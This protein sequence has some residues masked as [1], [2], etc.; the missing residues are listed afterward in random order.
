MKSVGASSPTEDDGVRRR[1]I[2]ITLIAVGLAGLIGTWGPF[3]GARGDLTCTAPAL[4]GETVDVSVSDTGAMMGSGHMLS[5][6][7]SP[8][9]VAPGEVSFIV[10][11]TG[12]MVHEFLVLPLPPGGAGSRPVGPDGRVSEAGSLGEASASCAEGTGAG[13]TPG[14]VSWITLRMASG[15][16]E[17]ICNEPGHYTSGM[18]TELDVR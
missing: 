4:P 5:V 3:S 9:A 1:T 14:S 13:I 17:L 6:V 12:V 7:A 16:Y 11:N 18:F 2:G 15:R 8:S 10:R